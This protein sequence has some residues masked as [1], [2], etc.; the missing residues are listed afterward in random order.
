MTAVEPHAFAL[1]RSK[2]RYP[3]RKACGEESMRSSLRCLVSPGD[4]LGALAVAAA[5]RRSSRPHAAS[6]RCPRQLDQAGRDARLSS[7]TR[8]R[9]TVPVSI[10]GR[11]PYPL[12]RRHRRRAHRHLRASWPAT[13]EL[14]PGRDR[15]RP[16]HD[17]GQP[18]PDRGHPRA[19]GRPADGRATSTRRRWPARNLGAAGHA[20]RRQ[21]AAS[22]A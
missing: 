19:R 2:G 18:D 14:G 12:H 22:S 6:R 16:Q 11:G 3:R 15:D 21:P 5:R 8:E 17:R 7:P 20:R 1:S 13:L 10:D 4:R 9:M